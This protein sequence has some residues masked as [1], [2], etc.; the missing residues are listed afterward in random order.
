M[1]KNLII[2]VLSKNNFFFLSDL[3]EINIIL[4]HQNH[5]M[6]VHEMKHNEFLNQYKKE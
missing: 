5:Q 4:E 6:F 1:T 2:N 3:I